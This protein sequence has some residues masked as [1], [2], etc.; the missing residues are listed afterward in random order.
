[1]GSKPNITRTTHTLPFD[2]LSAADFERMCLW[3][4]QRE[5]YE[6]VEHLGAAGHEQGR[7]IVAWREG[8]RYAFQCKRVQ[9]F[10]P[11]DALTEIDKVMA[12][13][14]H[15]RPS[16]L[17]FQVS[18]HVSATTREKARQ[19]VKDMGTEFWARTELDEKAKRHPDLVEEFF[20]GTR[21]W[22]F[23]LRK[24]A[25]SE[26]ICVPLAVLATFIAQNFVP[27]TASYDQIMFY[28]LACAVILGLPTY[29][30]CRFLRNYLHGVIA[31]FGAAGILLVLWL[32][33]RLVIHF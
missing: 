15:L 14:E 19:R 21:S 13:P 10:G 12:L 1:M 28:S 3:L 29:L 18:C 23:F 17:I 6:R 2:N 31:S 24:L 30:I 9:R 32:F 7:D 4:V 16:C 25:L 26:L 22:M 5:G 27:L 20:G 11:S 33:V 8:K